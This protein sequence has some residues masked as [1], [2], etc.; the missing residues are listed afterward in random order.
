[1]AKT[2]LPGDQ[3]Y[4]WTI[5]NSPISADGYEHTVL[6]TTTSS[7]QYPVG[8]AM[9]NSR[10]D[11]YRYVH[12]VAAVAA[13]DIVAQDVSVTS[14]GV[15]DNKATAAAI[16]ATEVTL[17]DTG[18][19]SADDAE[20][21]YA[22]GTLIIEDGAG[23]SH[24]YPIKGNTQGTSAGVVTLTL[25]EGLQV[26]LTTASDI[27]IIGSMYRNVR[28]ASTT[29]ALVSGVAVKAIGA[30]EYGWVQTWGVGAVTVDIISNGLVAAGAPAF[31]SD[32]DTGEAQNFGGVASN[33]TL[34]TGDWD[35][36]HIGYFLHTG[37]D[38]ATAGVY[39]QIT[40]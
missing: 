34:N 23:K 9:R 18:T 1:M 27:A 29:D 22:G 33:T 4:S 6:G 40:P 15:L 24:R 10:G 28:P 3:E 37:T 16:G 2:W 7:A 8:T 5:G 21:I 11:A 39:L 26:A 20:H 30:G 31:L 13:A 17:T 25:H 19:W 14:T 32:G 38:A 35:T 12:A 36:P